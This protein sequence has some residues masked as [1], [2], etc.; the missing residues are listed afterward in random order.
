MRTKTQ[1]LLLTIVGNMIIAG[2]FLG[3][4]NYREDNKS[5]QPSSVGEPLSAG[6][7]YDGE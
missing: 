7:G 2:I 3:L 1:L 6:L 5:Q 4:S